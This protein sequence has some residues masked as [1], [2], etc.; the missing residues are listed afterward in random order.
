MNKFL[1]VCFVFLFFIACSNEKENIDEKQHKN[2]KRVGMVVK[3]KKDMVDEYKKLH[4]DNNPG[5]RHLL[6]KYN[7]RNFSIFMV[8]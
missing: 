4:A 2:V 7:L 5:V 8:Q 3:I 6:T 1:S